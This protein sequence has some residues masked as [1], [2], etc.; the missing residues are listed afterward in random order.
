MANENRVSDMICNV[1][2]RNKFFD[3]RSALV[4]A[5]TDDYAMIHG[6]G[7]SKHAPTSGIMLT[8]TDYS[9]GKGDKSKFVTGIIPPFLIDKMLAVCRQNAGEHLG[10]NADVAAALGV[11]NAK[12]DRVYAGLLAGA[13][14]AV[15]ACSN[16]VSGKGHEKGPMADFGQVLLS[17]RKSL[18]DKEAGVQTFGIRDGHTEFTHHQERVNMYRKDPKD[19]FVFVSTVDITRRQYNEQGA[20]RKYPWVIKL[21]NFWAQP[22]EQAN[23]TTAYVSSSARDVTECFIQISDDDMHRCCYTAD[24]FIRVWENAVTIPLVLQGLELKQQARQNR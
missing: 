9:E 10:G 11:I 19:G 23:G 14:K 20:E 4:P 15:T 6:V 22:K 5:Y 1:G 24:H 7:G 17:M 16:L 18:T 3:M 2:G 8:I 12:M 13:A 21:R